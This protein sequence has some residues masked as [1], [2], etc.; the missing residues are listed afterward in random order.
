M[1]KVQNSRTAGQNYR[2]GT[3]PG[4]NFRDGTFPG[5]HFRDRSIPGQIFRETGQTFLPGT[6][7]SG[8]LE[9]LT[10]NSTMIVITEYK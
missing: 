3:F 9:T 8:Q 10:T 6:T 1:I 7:F 5:Q 2:N 4:Q